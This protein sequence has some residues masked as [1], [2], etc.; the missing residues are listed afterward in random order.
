MTIPVIFRLLPPALPTFLAPI[1][2]IFFLAFTDS[3]SAT[4]V[5]QIPL[6]A[7]ALPPRTAAKH[8]AL[9][10][11]PVTVPNVLPQ[12]GHSWRQQACLR[13]STPSLFSPGWDVIPG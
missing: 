11:R 4:C 5:K 7:I 8:P 10:T 3:Q 2:I 9:H 1:T 12:S 6:G 13:A